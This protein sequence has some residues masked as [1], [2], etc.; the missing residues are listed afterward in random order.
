M[1]DPTAVVSQAAFSMSILVITALGLAIIFGMMGVINL[2][3][4]ALITV[5]A[6]VAYAVTQ[7][8]LGL[9][10]AF[11]VSPIIV[12]LVGLV[13]EI[14]VI[15]RLYDRPLDTLLATWGMALV[16]QELIKVIFGS[17]AQSISNPYSNPIDLFGAILPLYRIFLVGLA[18]VLVLATFAAFKYTDFGI[19]AR[20]VIQNDEMASILGTDVDR[21]YRA[22]FAIGAALAGLAGTAVAPIVGAGPRVGLD[23]LVRSFFVVIVGGTGELL[24]GTIGGAAL[25]GGSSAV[26]S[27]FSSQT[28]AQTIVFVFA[29]IIIR[30]R[31]EGIFG[32]S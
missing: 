14:T 26:L 16:I 12:G 3:H 24:A 8:G 28:F 31:P 29:I 4:G 23:Y 9:W 1:V 2:A 27:F 20:A 17:S 22:T 13:M 11:L 32:G 10:V 5:G 7:A 21:I 6:Y 30:L 25:I 15:K 18:A 19:K